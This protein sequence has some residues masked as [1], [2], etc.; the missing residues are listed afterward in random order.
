MKKDP[1]ECESFSISLLEKSKAES[2]I[3]GS[4]KANFIL[5]FLEKKKGDYGKSIIYYLEGIRYA[6]KANYPEVGRDL[7]YLFQNSGNIFKKFGNYELARRYYE[8]AMEVASAKGDF[9]KYTYLVLLSAKVLKEEGKYAEAT[10]LLLTTFSDFNHIDKETIADIYNQLG[11][12][13]TEQKNEQLAIENFQK[14]IHFVEKEEQL[15]SKYTGRAYHN[16]GNFYFMSEQYEKAIRYYEK[17]IL[18]KESSDASGKS[19]FITYKDLS[20]SYLQLKLYD[21]ANFYANKA[22]VYYSEAKSVPRYYEL[23]KF[24]SIINKVTGNVS[25]YSKYQDLYASSLESYLAEQHEIEA[26]DKK[27]NLDLITQR[28]FA[29]VAEQERNQQIQYYS[30]V[31]GSILVSMILLIIAFFQYR[32]YRLRKD[33]EASLRPYVKDTM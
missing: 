25:E 23:Y 8:Q 17:A 32:K 7:I 24:K 29:L 21:S 2:N 31:G 11:F 1:V 14:L 4:V 6:K 22:E 30:T 27:Y 13:H 15:K 9:N 10:E 3:Y 28:Y 33:L 20:D 26:A 12:I 18:S 19:L 5:G 16:I